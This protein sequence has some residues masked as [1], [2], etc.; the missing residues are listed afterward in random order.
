MDTTPQVPA[1]SPTL[2]TNVL[3]TQRIFSIDAF[4]G[5]TILVMIFVNELA[6]VGGLPAWTKHAEADA[7]T[8]TYVDVVFPAFLFI[9]GMS[10][11]FIT[12][13]QRSPCNC[14]L[15]NGGM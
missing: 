11:P 14:R 3:A 9:V 4:R 5:V 7:N 2:T 15:P 1:T 13:V 8:M 10:V 6:G 12:S